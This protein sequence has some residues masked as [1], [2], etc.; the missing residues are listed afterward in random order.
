MEIEEK[1]FAAV[2]I[3]YL[4]SQISACDNMNYCLMLSNLFIN[5]SGWWLNVV[6]DLQ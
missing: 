1:N 6:S 5:I 3:K 4:S 2:S